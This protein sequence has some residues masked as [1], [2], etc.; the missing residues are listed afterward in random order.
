MAA[1]GSS[2]W[3]LRAEH[4][5]ALVGDPVETSIDE[6]YN[7]ASTALGLGRVI[8]YAIGAPNSRFEFPP[9]ATIPGLGAVQIWPDPRA[10]EWT[11]PN[12]LD[13]QAAWFLNDIFRRWITAPK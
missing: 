6:P 12:V 13:S 5:G 1:N 10:L 7:S 9:I 8:F 4:V 2:D 11:R 3:A